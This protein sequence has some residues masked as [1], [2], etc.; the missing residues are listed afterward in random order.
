MI[1]ALMSTRSCACTI[2]QSI[3]LKLLLLPFLPFTV[4]TLEA[5]S[6]KPLVGRLLSLKCWS[7]NRS[8]WTRLTLLECQYSS[9][10]PHW[11]GALRTI[12]CVL[13]WEAKPVFEHTCLASS[14]RLSI[15]LSSQHSYVFTSLH[16]WLNNVTKEVVCSI[17]ERSFSS[18]SWSLYEQQLFVTHSLTCVQCGSFTE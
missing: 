17:L 16:I 7:Q 3:P 15:L 10:Y 5:L 4:C 14:F 18:F 11:S 2:T 9:S 8:C 12:A 6:R 13:W 1:R